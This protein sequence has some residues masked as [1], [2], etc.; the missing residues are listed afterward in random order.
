MDGATLQAKLY[1]GYAKAAKRIGLPFAQYRPQAALQPALSS[2]NGV[3]TL[4]ASFNAEDMGYRHPR[5]YARV[6]WYCVADGGQL[7]AGDYLS[8]NGYTYFIAAMEPL[9]P[10][11]AVRCNR[12]LSVFRPQQQAGVG[13]VGYG[14][15]TAGNE[16][17]RLTQF[18]ASILLGTKGEHS[19]VDL[20]GDVRSPWWAIL[21]PNLPGGVTLRSGDLMQDDLGRRFVVSSAEQSALGW[22]VGAMEAET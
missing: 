14:G 13:A 18:P 5:G 3:Q 19:L 7:Q 6:G 21:L 9:L 2:A 1:G 22:R 4:L 15:M 10:I 11:L 17:P 20:P 16:M 8:G 12:V